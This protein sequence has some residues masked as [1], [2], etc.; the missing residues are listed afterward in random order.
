[1]EALILR[2]A[3]SGGVSRLGHSRPCDDAG[4]CFSSALGTTNTDI[5]PDLVRQGLSL[6]VQSNAP[7][8]YTLAV[9]PHVYE[10]LLAAWDATGTAVYRFAQTLTEDAQRRGIIDELYGVN[11]VIVSDLEAGTSSGQ[12]D[13]ADITCGMFSAGALG[14][15]E[16]WPVRIERQRDASLRGYELVATACYGVG[17]IQDSWGVGLL[18]DNKD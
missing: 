13:A 16:K 14:Y 11:V 6:L 1:M 4:V 3:S 7:A 17:E 5:T 9:T 2:Q 15:V 12:R 10:D 18:V 8:P